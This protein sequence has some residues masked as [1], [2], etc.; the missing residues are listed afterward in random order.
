MKERQ[1]LTD[2]A[3][4]KLNYCYHLRAKNE[5]SSRIFST[6]TDEE[7]GMS[8]EDISYHLMNIPMTWQYLAIGLFR[9]A[10]DF[11]YQV[12]FETLTQDGVTGMEMHEPITLGMINAMV[13]EPGVNQNDLYEMVIIAKPYAPGNDIPIE[14]I[15]DEYRKWDERFKTRHFYGFISETNWSKHGKLS[16]PKNT[17]IQYRPRGGK[18]RR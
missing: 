12:Y 3:K 10:K 8:W 13:R 18:K 15:L 4:E 9:T 11:E 5:K 1:P 14:D 2:S 16:P 6:Y 7:M 17:A